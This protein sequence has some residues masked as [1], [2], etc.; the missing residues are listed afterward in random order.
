MP[1]LCITFLLY[2]TDL[3]FLGQ[4]NLDIY[5]IHNIF[6]LQE[7]YQPTICLLMR[8]GVAQAMA[9]A[10][11]MAMADKDHL[12]TVTIRSEKWNGMYQLLKF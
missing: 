12:G 10:M 4:T 8:L 11:A 1:C 7:D 5:D 3:T 2:T 9:M 6:K